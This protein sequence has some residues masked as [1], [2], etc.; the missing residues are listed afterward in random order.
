MSIT[1]INPT[2]D[3]IIKNYPEMSETEIKDIIEKTQTAFLKW[4]EFD[5]KQRAV[6]MRKLAEIFRLRKNDYAILMAQEMG[7][8]VS[9]GKEEIEKCAATC[10][11][12]ADHAENYLKPQRIQTEMSKNTVI[13]QPLGIV[14]A[15]MPWNFPFWQVLRF[16][17]PTLMAGNAALLKH[18][19]ISTGTALAIEQLFFDA[20]FPQDLFRAL[21]IREEK[22]ADVIAHQHVIA[23]TLTGSPKAGKAVATAAASH[24]KPSVLE[25]G[26]N[27]PYLILEDAD[28]ELAA[29]ACIFSRMKNAGQVCI[30]AK[31]LIVHKI[32]HEKF[33]KIILEKLSHYKMGNPLDEKTHFGP[34]ARKDLRDNVHQQ[35]QDSIKKGAQL[36]LGG[37]LPSEKGFYYPPTVLI[38]VK[39]GMPAY[40]E[41]LFGPVIAIIKANDEEEAI[42]IANDSIYGL[43]AAVFTKDIQRGE[44]IAAEKIQVGTC[45]VN[46]WVASDWRLPFGGIKHSGYGRE[47]AAE[48]IRSFTNVKTINIR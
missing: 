13:F 29:D 22:A 36:I 34:L 19:P 5:F 21:I 37:T 17:A 26:G 20:G 43:S 7:K 41:E 33:L 30:A 35:V 10:E 44:K 6:P 1:T 28:L 40:V 16:A 3:E 11:Y 12:Y 8:P 42:A 32:I 48:G 46:T 27:D 18:A 39:K 24:L 14:F 9:Q 31:R 25:L 47:L 2:T 15:I 38:N 4:R 45:A 23:V